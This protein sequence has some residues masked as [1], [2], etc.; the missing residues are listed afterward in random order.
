MAAKIRFSEKDAAFLSNDILA[1]SPP[2]KA[3]ALIRISQ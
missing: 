3:L 1:V 2:S